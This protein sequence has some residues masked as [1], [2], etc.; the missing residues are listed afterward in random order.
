M[1]SASSRL[2]SDLHSCCGKHKRRRRV[3]PS[4]GTHTQTRLRQSFLRSL[5]QATARFTAGSH[6]DAEEVREQRGRLQRDMVLGLG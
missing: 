1:T 6:P 2:L 5:A 3:T 4:S